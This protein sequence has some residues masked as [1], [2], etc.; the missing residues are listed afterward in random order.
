MRE[1]VSIVVLVDDEVFMIRR[2]PFLKAFPG[3]WAFPGGKVDKEDLD[4]SFE[5]TALSIIRNDLAHTLIREAM[6]ELQFDF[7]KNE[8]EGNIISV[9]DLGLAMTPD[10]NPHR[11][12]TYFV[13]VELKEKPQFV[14]DLNEAE[15][16]Q[17]S[18]TK[19]FCDLY[20]KGEML[21]VP[22]IINLL[23]IMG[24]DPKNS[25]GHKFEFTYD[26]DTSVPCIESISG[27]KQFL[28]LSN[29]LPPANRTNCLLVGGVLIDP[30]PKS[31]EEK[32]KLLFSMKD[33]EVKK[34]F[35]THHH[36]DH[37]EYSNEIAIQLGVSIGM[38]QKC[39][40]RIE[41]NNGKDYLSKNEIEIFKEGDVLTKWKGEDV[42]V[43]EVPGH[44]DSQL[45]V[46]PRSL[47]WFLVGDLIQGIGTVVIGRTSGNMSVYFKSLEKVIK[48]RPKVIYPSHGIAMGDVYRIEKTLDHRKLR[49][50]QIFE[51]HT[52]GLSDQEILMKIYHGVDKR[53]WPFALDN[54]HMHLEKL[55]LE[56]K[57]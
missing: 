42:L 2:Q 41:K 40:Q 44:A 17:W 10:F 35:L 51:L 34:I 47:K 56:K 33:E 1:A 4:A 45:A 36:Q 39:E 52:S 9:V 19:E 28:P 7:L 21:V 46:A 38:S 57:V 54:I 23:R 49:E 6:E 14:V 43:H 50:E 11:Y 18:T 26:S 13:L 32:D 22:P 25:K 24:D 30:S 31:V 5:S 53:L 3:Y 8:I 55:R 16:F 48:L 27:V 29:T 15:V 12:A 37:Y 20:E